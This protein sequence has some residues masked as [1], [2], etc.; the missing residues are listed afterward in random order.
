MSVSDY[1]E[2]KRLIQKYL[3]RAKF[4]GPKT[5]SDI[6]KAQERLGAKFPPLYRLF[7]EEYGSGGV[8][9]FEIYGLMNDDLSVTGI[10]RVVWYT[11]KARQEWGLPRT[12]IPIFDLGDGEVFCLDLDKI[13]PKSEEAP[14]IAY[15]PGYP[16][17]EQRFDLI[18]KDFGEFFLS[19]MILEEKIQA[20]IRAIK[21]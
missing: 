6:N 17:E 4:S 1:E 5:G 10:P 7:L 12:L 15:S 3:D 19:R 13:D 2:A 8:G 14:I 21:T 11:E 18:A 16:L 20:R 9:S